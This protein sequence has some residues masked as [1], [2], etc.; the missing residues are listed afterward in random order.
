MHTVD[1][2]LIVTCVSYLLP[3]LKLL[4][5]L[6]SGG[7]FLG[8]LLE[9]LGAPSHRT[10]T[11]SSGHQ[12]NAGPKYGKLVPVVKVLHRVDP[13]HLWDTDCTCYDPEAFLRPLFPL[14]TLLC[15]SLCAW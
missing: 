12:A 1:K 14:R 11:Y 4:G 13:V 9:C 3:L 15:L 7:L 6:W 10:G 2:L 8:A 5:S